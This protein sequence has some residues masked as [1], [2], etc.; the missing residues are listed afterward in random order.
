MIRP[1]Y[2]HCVVTENNQNHDSIVLCSDLLL[3]RRKIFIY[4]NATKILI[5]ILANLIKLLK[6][7]YASGTV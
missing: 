3:L 7:A 1:A 6:Q 4:D 2:L 5:K